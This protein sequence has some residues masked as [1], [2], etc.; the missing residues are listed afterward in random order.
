MTN[1]VLSKVKHYFLKDFLRTIY[2]ASFHPNQSYGCQIWGQSWTQSLQKLEVLQNKA[3]R[4]LTFKGLRE[5]NEPF[6][7]I[8]KTFKL[9]YLIWIDNLD[10]VQNYL[11]GF[12]PKNGLNYFTKTT[13][14]HD[15]HTR[16]IRINVSIANT[17]YH[18]LLELHYSQ[19]H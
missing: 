8:S 5:N 17:T 4:I 10:F 13:Y 16:K 11:N 15:H 14:Q 7:K 6:L 9:K 12:L 18:S 19:S 1:F 2:H 3:L